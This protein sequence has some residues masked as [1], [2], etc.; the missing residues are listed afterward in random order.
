MGNPP[1]RPRR[2]SIDPPSWVAHRECC[3]SSPAKHLTDT[4]SV[5]D[6]GNMP[7]FVRIA[8]ASQRGGHR[9]VADATRAQSRCDRALVTSTRT[10]G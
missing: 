1:P 4:G 6:A 5:R 7:Q 9:P 8:S 2:G 3:L 10:G